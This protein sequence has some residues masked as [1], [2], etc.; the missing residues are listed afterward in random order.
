[1]LAPVFSPQPADKLE[2]SGAATDDND[3]GLAV[4]RALLGT[5][6]QR[7]PGADYS[8]AEKQNRVESCR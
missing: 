6:V 3:L 1:M 5:A 2:P 8:R 7:N 4:H